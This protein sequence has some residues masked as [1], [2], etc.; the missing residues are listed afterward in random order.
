MDH[1]RSEVNNQYE[2]SHIT[3][4]IH[5]ATKVVSETPTLEISLSQLLDFVVSSIFTADLSYDKQV[6]MFSNNSEESHGVLIE[7]P[8]IA[9]KKNQT[10]LAPICELTS[11]CPCPS[12]KDGNISL[13]MSSL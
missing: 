2:S 8:F 6:R 13:K 1:Q 12:Y 5:S 7:K 9:K 11:R 3:P 10:S 4:F